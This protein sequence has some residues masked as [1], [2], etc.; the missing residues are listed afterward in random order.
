MKTVKE[1]RSDLEQSGLSLLQAEAVAR[2]M[3]LSPEEQEVARAAVVSAYNDLIARAA[4][5]GLGDLVCRI[6]AAVVEA[7][8]R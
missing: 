3:T 6:L 4:R 8:D 5:I 1:I 7:D 2:G